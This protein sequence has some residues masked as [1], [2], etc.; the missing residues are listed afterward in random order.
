MLTDLSA[1]G[2]LTISAVSIMATTVTLTAVLDL[3]HGLVIF[4]AFASIVSTITSVV[5]GGLLC[6]GTS[7]SK[8]LERELRAVTRQAIRLPQES[9]LIGR[10]TT[11]W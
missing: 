1:P 10:D 3:G 11:S 5:C 4:L 6:W 7:E 9:E 8:V 2:T